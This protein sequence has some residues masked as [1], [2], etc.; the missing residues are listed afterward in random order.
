VPSV[1]PGL[2]AGVKPPEAWT[3]KSFGSVQTLALTTRYGWLDV[4]VRSDGTSGYADLL[5]KAGREAI[6]GA[7]IN[8]ADI[9]DLIRMKEAIG[10]VKYLSHLPLLRELRAQLKRE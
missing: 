9:D 10:D 6:G 2:E 7:E 8:V 1:E 5:A 3:A 4:V